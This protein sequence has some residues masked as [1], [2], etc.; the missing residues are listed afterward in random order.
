VFP[1]S[2]V[3]SFGAALIAELLWGFLGRQTLALNAPSHCTGTGMGSPVHV[4]DNE[5]DLKR[6][7]FYG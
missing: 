2:F 1:C 3:G 5:N 4:K 7:I 6:R